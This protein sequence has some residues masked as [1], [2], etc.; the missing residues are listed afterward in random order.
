MFFKR[1]FPT[2]IFR[3]V[4]SIPCE[5]LE[6]ENIKG[7][8]FDMDNTLVDYKYEYADEARRWLQSVRQMGIKCCILSN[9]P[10]KN[11]AK[12]IA[13]KLDMGYIVNASKPRI[14]GFNK[15]IEL[16]G[17]DKE[18]VAIVGDQIFTDI[19]GGN[20]FGIKTI[21][22]K[23]IVTKEFF[24]TRIKRPLEKFVLNKYEKYNKGDK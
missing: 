5:L 4:E 1:F 8:I 12:Q 9:T 10:R 19:W 23:P 11:K 18:N 21:L 3:S 6:K 14:K 13:E 7:L 17:I 15:A 22:V 24:V 2:Y 20:R 16:L